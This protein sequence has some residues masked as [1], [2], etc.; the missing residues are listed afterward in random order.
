MLPLEFRLGAGSHTCGDLLAVAG[1]EEAVTRAE[2]DA[3]VVLTARL[4]GL[5]PLAVE[6]HRPTA[7]DAVHRNRPPVSPQ[8]GFHHDWLYQE[9]IN[10]KSR[11]NVRSIGN[12]PR[13]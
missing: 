4:V 10:D 12:D 7:T 9:G 5:V 3:N 1:A 6:H 11:I 8:R 13:E 2:V